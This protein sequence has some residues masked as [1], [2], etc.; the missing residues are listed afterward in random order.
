M[1]EAVRAM[2]PGEVMTPG[3]QE[4]LQ[5]AAEILRTYGHGQLAQR[6]RNISVQHYVAI[7][8]NVIATQ[9]STR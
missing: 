9:R 4:A 7:E 3:E 2:A 5:R 1:V 8:R 6:V